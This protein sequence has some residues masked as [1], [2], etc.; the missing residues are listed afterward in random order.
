MIIPPVRTVVILTLTDVRVVVYLH[1]RRVQLA[2]HGIMPQEP[3]LVVPRVRPTAIHRAVGRPA[4][5]ACMTR[6]AQR[7]VLRH[8][9][10]V[11]CIIRILLNVQLRRSTTH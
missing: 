6:D 2:K 11:Q 9:R 3:V 4:V 8:V 10:R 5:T 1:R 7:G